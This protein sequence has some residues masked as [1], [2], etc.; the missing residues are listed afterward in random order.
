MTDGKLEQSAQVQ[1]WTTGAEI[2]EA[3]GVD[4]DR[5]LDATMIRL[6][7]KLS[8][9]LNRV[10]DTWYGRFKESRYVGNYPSKGVLLHCH[11]AKL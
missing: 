10:R 8:D 5:A 9:D 7:G 6:L 3:F 4:V 11:F 2:Y 1:F